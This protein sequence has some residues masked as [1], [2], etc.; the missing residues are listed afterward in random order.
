MLAIVKYMM[1]LG[2]AALILV[3]IYGVV[4][5][6]GFVSILTFGIIFLMGAVPVALPAVLAIVQSVG[7]VSYRKRCA[8]DETGFN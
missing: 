3:A 4:I 6:T 1:Y 5:G 2:I 7:A 8:G